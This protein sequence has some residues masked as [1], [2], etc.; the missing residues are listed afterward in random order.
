MCTWCVCVC[1]QAVEYY[2]SAL[3]QSPQTVTYKELGRVYL[4][5]GSLDNA[6]DIYKKAVK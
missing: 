6:V 1:V 3:Q 4:L 5:Q 2:L